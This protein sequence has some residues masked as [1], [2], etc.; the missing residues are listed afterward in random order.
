MH[1]SPLDIY[2]LSGARIMFARKEH[3]AAPQLPVMNRLP[4]HTR[5]QPQ[6]AH[7]GAAIDSD[8]VTLEPTPYRGD[9]TTSTPNATDVGATI[10][11]EA[12]VSYGSTQDAEASEACGDLGDPVQGNSTTFDKPCSF[13]SLWKLDICEAAHGND[14]RGA[15]PAD[16]DS[17]ED[18]SVGLDLCDLDDQVR[19]LTTFC[20]S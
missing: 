9:R 16:S 7:V 4:T 14:F 11:G 8:R 12:F 5:N 18:S 6:N 3:N 2:S 17:N 10:S 1:S 19:A 13:L 15:L 20:F